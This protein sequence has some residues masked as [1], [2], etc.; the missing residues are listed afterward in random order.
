MTVDQDQNLDFSNAHQPRT[1]TFERALALLDEPTRS[2]QPTQ[3][4]PRLKSG[5][6]A[7]GDETFSN[8]SM[9]A[10]LNSVC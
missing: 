9:D 3:R 8:T 1:T 6:E 10:S 5:L 2:H 4:R 7:D